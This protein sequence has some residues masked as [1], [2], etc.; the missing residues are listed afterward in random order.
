MLMVVDILSWILLCTGA[1]LAVISAVGLIRFPDFYSRCHAAG[2][3]DSAAMVMILG[4]LL[5][6]APD[7]AVGIRLLFLLV[8]LLFTG[9]VSTHALTQSAWLDGLRPWRK[10][11]S[12]KRGKYR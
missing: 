1:L 9:P 5:L 6:Q 2:V 12:R 10:G 4:G 11:D 3:G 7:M 8:F